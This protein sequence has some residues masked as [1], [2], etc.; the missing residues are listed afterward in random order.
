MDFRGIKQSGY[1]F[2]RGR[3]VV[4][5]LDGEDMFLESELQEISGAFP[6]AKARVLTYTRK[7]VID[8]RISI[9]AQH[10]LVRLSKN[11]ATSADSVKLTPI[12]NEKLRATVE[13]RV[14]DKWGR[15]SGPKKVKGGVLENKRELEEELWGSAWK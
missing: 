10:S 13:E 5:V 11:P 4:V 15:R 7:G 2:R 12:S 6:S 9:P 3:T 8:N 1:W 14:I